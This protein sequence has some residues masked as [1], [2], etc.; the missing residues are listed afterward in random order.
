MDRDHARAFLKKVRREAEA[1]L[2][3]LQQ[4]ELDLENSDDWVATVKNFAP[5]VK[6]YHRGALEGWQ[7]F[8]L[9]L[10]GERW[11]YFE[12]LLR[13]TGGLAP[14][15]VI[16]LEQFLCIWG[17]GHFGVQNTLC[18]CLGV[19]GDSALK[20]SQ[21]KDLPSFFKVCLYVHHLLAKALWQEEEPRIV[22]TGDDDGMWCAI[23]W[24]VIGHALVTS[25]FQWFMCDALKRADGPWNENWAAVLPL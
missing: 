5:H 17:F 7:R 1:F 16:S 9:G 20:G 12:L 18:M 15:L 2:S 21:K 8:Y 23:Y 11:R 4:Y 3:D 22:P 13:A 14:A 24:L 19:L 25:V 6:S 10:D